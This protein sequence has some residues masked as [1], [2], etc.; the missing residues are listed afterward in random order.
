MTPSKQYAHIMEAERQFKA[1]TIHLIDVG[2]VPAT[3]VKE[4][5]PG[6]VVIWNYGVCQTVKGITQLAS[7]TALVEFSD[8]SSRVMRS[9]KRMG[10]RR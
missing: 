4:L 7:A 1:D 9:T 2:R 3:T 8:G 10:V 5:R 6:D